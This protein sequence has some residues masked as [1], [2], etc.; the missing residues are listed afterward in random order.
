MDLTV[1]HDGQFFVGII[2]CKEKR[3]VV[4]SEV[5]F[6]NGTFRRRSAYICERFNVSVF[7][8]LC[9][10]W[11]GSE[12]KTASQKYKADHTTSSKKK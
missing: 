8:A 2:T 1:Y 6:W 4:W 5:Y 7:S 12:R 10:M 3:E 9:K 11:R